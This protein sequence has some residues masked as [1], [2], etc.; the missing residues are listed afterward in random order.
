MRYYYIT[1]MVLYCISLFNKIYSIDVQNMIYIL[2][3]IKIIYLGYINDLHIN[4]YII[5]KFLVTRLQNA[6]LFT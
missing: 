1:Y 4:K 6:Y 5:S 3:L 2:Y